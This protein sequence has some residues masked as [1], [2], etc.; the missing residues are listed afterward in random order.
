[1]CVPIL[2]SA[3]SEAVTIGKLKYKI[4]NNTATVLG[5]ADGIDSVQDLYIPDCVEYNGV[6]YNV[7]QIASSAFAFNEQIFGTLRLSENLISIGPYAFRD[8]T[9][10]TG[11]LHLPKKLETI[12]M[13]AFYNCTNFSSEL[14]IPDS[15]KSI[16]TSAFEGCS[17]FTG[18]LKI[19]D[20]IEIVQAYTFSGCSGLNGTL[21]IGSL[22]K[23]I[24]NDAFRNC[25]FS[26]ELI[27]PESVS[28]IEE[29]AF[30]DCQ[31]FVGDLKIPDSVE[32]IS[33]N[34][35]CRIGCDGILKIGNSLKIIGE[36]AFRD[37]HFHGL[38]DLPKSL[39]KIES[40]AFYGCSGFSGKLLIPNSVESIGSNAFRN[41]SGFDGEL[42]I[43]SAVKTIRS[44]AFYR[45]KFSGS[46]IIPNSVNIIEE[47][48]FMGCERFDG[49]LI[50]GNSIT[51]IGNFAFANCSGLHGSLN[52]PESITT[53]GESAFANCSNLDGNLTFPE[54]I[55][56]I[57]THAF[58]KCSNLKGDL[59]IPSSLKEIAD[60]AFS[61]CSSLNG[62]LTIPETVTKIGASAFSYCSNLT[63]NL[64]I[65]NTVESIGSNAFRDC[66]SLNGNLHI[67]ENIKGI[68]SGVF[69][70]CS[71]LIG[72]LS[73]PLTATYI[74]SAAF[75]ECSGFTG[76]LIIPETVTELEERAFSGCSG[77]SSIKI[78]A[79][80]KQIKNSTF[81]NCAG[82]SGNIEI[83]NTVEIIWY[84]A[85]LNV[86]ADC[87]KLPASLKKIYGRAFYG[88][89]HK[90]IICEATTPPVTGDDYSNSGYVFNSYIGSE[91][92]RKYYKNASLYVPIESIEKYREQREWAYF[93]NIYGIGDVDARSIT[94]NRTEATLRASETVDLVATILPETTTD[95][96]VIWKSSNESI[97]TVDVN[98]K[99]TAVKVGNAT[100]TATAASGV[101]ASC[102]I[103]VIETPAASITVENIEGDNLEMHVGEVK[104][105]KVTVLPETTTDKSVTFESSNPEI[106]SVDAEGNVK[107]L[108]L[109]TATIK[110]T[111][112]SG[113]STSITVTVVATPAGS[114]TLNKTEITLK[115]TETVD[116][117]ATILPETTTDKSVTWKSSDE[118]VATVDT[119][120]KVSAVKVGKAI[121]TA[122]AASG[123]TATCELTVVETPAESVKISLTYAIVRVNEAVR[124][125]ATVQPE[126]ATDKT[127]I[128]QS[129]DNHIANVDTTGIV[130]GVSPGKVTII[131][132]A[133]SGVSA[134]CKVTVVPRKTEPITVTRSDELMVIMDGEEAQM[135]VTVTGG[136]SEG[137]SF[138]WTNKGQTVGTNNNLSVTGH[139]NGDKVSRETYSVHVVDICDGETLFDQTFEFVVE[140]WPKPS[141]NIEIDGVS[142]TNNLKIR[143]NNLLE[144]SAETPE[145]GYDNQ[146][147][148]TWSLNGQIV[149]T[150]QNMSQVMTMADGKEQ[151][152]EDVSLVVS[153]T[154]IG[155]DGTEWGEAVSAPVNVAVYR[156]PLTPVQLLRK[157]N[158]TTHT[159]VAMSQYSDDE[160]AKLG[161]TFVYGYSDAGGEEHVVGTTA[162]RY[163]RFNESVYNNASCEKWVYAQWTYN[164]GSIVTSGKRYLD[165]RIDEDFD[166]SDFSDNDKPQNI[167]DYSDSNNW[168]RSNSR[169]GISITVENATDTRIE[170]FTTSG[171]MVESNLIPA[172]TYSSVDFTRD[173][174]AN[175]VYIVVVTSGETRVVKKVLIK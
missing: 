107:A 86:K 164:D 34:A 15:V 58:D 173:N 53:I 30:C 169:G 155:P 116:L 104:C 39:R 162:K 24:E 119:N 70:G 138:T 1:M 102:A 16:A 57:G 126:T 93:E 14:K 32:M 11:S 129:S 134:T 167:I 96:S 62:P 110:I 166:A 19:P 139:S 121:I 105:I 60:Y 83:P 141:S 3:Q 140:T 142:G 36:E 66:S 31:Q 174:V 8:C 81:K 131:A 133:V 90:K 46:L 175:G 84:D 79:Q 109:G 152:T 112:K 100:I 163:C 68:Y 35:F 28:I 143:E 73:I 56:S 146:W 135:S 63:G 123:V 149:S 125:T 13:L 122:T 94:L 6:E 76:C 82:I 114:I 148:F 111:A 12:G 61:S 127:I 101:T 20:K 2:C 132:T 161:Y 25:N 106:A 118:A 29:Y 48:A 144:L 69:A 103:T 10:L 43:G 23:T 87:I 65:P 145:G 154:N 172:D 165:G 91:D 50:L 27:I 55:T 52:F 40:H 171:Q 17:G 158:G 4:Y 120:G 75:S 99:V 22:V 9:N 153:A 124:L 64:W 108:A 157:G 92:Y 137:L 45:C 18:S 170:I 117:V 72:N 51:I 54:S 160:L 78:N 77:F 88:N 7:T 95:K 168:I 21:N 80:L 59:K 38:L 130:T 128:W 147:N 97:A 71:E 151:A 98:G 67:S 42:V 74:G 89:M 113:I 5:L 136:Y 37:C 33:R 115:A 49:N 41:C 85:F 47:N 44:F 26:G 159:L 150:D 156:R